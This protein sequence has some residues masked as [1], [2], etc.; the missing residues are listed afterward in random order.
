MGIAFLPIGIGS[1]VG[2]KF[3]GMLIRHFGE[4]TH[5]PDRIWWAVTGVG[6]A[7]AALLWIYDKTFKAATAV[8]AK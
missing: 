1:L 7:T 8:P 4:V 6:V 2:G 5:Q 3:G